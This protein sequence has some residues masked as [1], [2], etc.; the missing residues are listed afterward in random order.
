M[1]KLTAQEIQKKLAAPFMKTVNGKEYPAVKWLPKD[2]KSN[3]GKIM[4]VPFVDRELVINR[5]NDVMGVDGWQFEVKREADGTKT[6]TLSLLIGNDWISRSDTGT[7]SKNEGEKGSTSDALKRAATHFGIGVYLYSIG[8][9]W[10]NSKPNS[11]GKAQPVDN[12]GRF[13]YGDQVSS[14]LNGMSTEQGA[15][16][17]LLTLQPDLWKREEIKKLWN[18]FKIK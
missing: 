10:I 17:Q 7:P 3:A 4:C 18:E 16:A 15:L 1:E 9:K 13:L 8:N 11:K 14:F 2:T 6:G 12:S 5:L